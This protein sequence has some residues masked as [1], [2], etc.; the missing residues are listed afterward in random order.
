MGN[1]KEKREDV[2][3]L[4][5]YMSFIYDE[6]SSVVREIVQAASRRIVRTIPKEIAKTDRALVVFLFHIFQRGNTLVN[7]RVRRCDIK[8]EA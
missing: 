8:W 4:H 5:V 1:R 2:K 6:K 7:G 3:I